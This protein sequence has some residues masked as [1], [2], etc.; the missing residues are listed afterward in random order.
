M[1]RWE[2]VV[3]NNRDRGRAATRWERV[4]LIVSEKIFDHDQ[5]YGDDAPRLSEA[6]RTRR[7]RPTRAC[8][9]P[10]PLSLTDPASV[11]EGS[12]EVR[13]QVVKKIP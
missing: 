12:L 13:K 9:R 7:A 4:Y 1:S 6:E 11:T 2:I 5:A 8:Q 10:H 3:E